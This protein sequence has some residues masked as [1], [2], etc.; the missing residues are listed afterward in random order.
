MGSLV[1]NTVLA[2]FTASLFLASP[3]AVKAGEIPGVSDNAGSSPPQIQSPPSLPQM[4][5][6]FSDGGASEQFSWVL[7]LLD[8]LKACRAERLAG[9]RT[10]C[11]DDLT[12][13]A[14]STSSGP[15]EKNI[16]QTPKVGNW[17]VETSP[18]GVVAAGVPAVFVED[19]TSEKTKVS[20]FFRCRHDNQMDIYL[21]FSKKIAKAN[22]P[23]DVA[24]KGDDNNDGGS[25]PW[26]PSSGG[27]AI[28]LWGTER[29]MPMIKQVARQRHTS[30]RITL[31][32]D[33][34]LF[35]SFDLLGIED[36]MTPLRQTCKTSW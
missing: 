25:Q 2:S 16:S 4:R 3:F 7:T 34:T 36:A 12:D 21:V 35:A 28:G 29:S 22:L 6:S 18:S 31:P 11:Y 33:K 10:K 9:D 17:A 14:T 15:A 13:K 27:T 8:G 5:K 32:D 30:V 23:L 26:E 24:V 1:K 19:D 20:L